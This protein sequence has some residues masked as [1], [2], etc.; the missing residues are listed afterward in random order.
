MKLKKNEKVKSAGN[1]QVNVG[2]ARIA[3]GERS[4]Q[5]APY[6]VQEVV[7]KDNNGAFSI[8]GFKIH[9]KIK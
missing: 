2:K 7:Y 8:F 5:C 1:A 3:S 6:R 4:C 9:N